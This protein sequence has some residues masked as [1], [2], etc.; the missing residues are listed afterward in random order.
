MCQSPEIFCQGHRACLTEACETAGGLPRA[1]TDC[2][3]S[4]KNV[5][6]MDGPVYGPFLSRAEVPFH[7]A[8]A[9]QPFHTLRS[10]TFNTLMLIFRLITRSGLARSS[11]TFPNDRIYQ[12]HY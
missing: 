6:R 1:R 5:F 11:P 4:A 2:P 8:G 3:C 12:S 7:L 9:R 10:E